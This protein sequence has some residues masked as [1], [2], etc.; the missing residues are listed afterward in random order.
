MQKKLLYMVWHRQQKMH[1][2][3]DQH[4]VV[5]HRSVFEPM[6]PAHR[7]QTPKKA[8]RQERR[9]PKKK[10]SKRE[11]A[12][13]WMDSGD[14]SGE[15]SGD[16][17]QSA[18]SPEAEAEAAPLPDMPEH[19]DEVKTLAEFVR[20]KP[21]LI[22]SAVQI[23]TQQHVELCATA[24]RLRYF[25]ADLFAEVY[26]VLTKRFLTNEIDARAATEIAGHLT[27]LNAYDEKVFSAAIASLEPRFHTLSKEQRLR[28]LSILEQ[29]QHRSSPA[30]VDALRAAP[31][32]EDI[33]ITTS[34]SGKVPC[35]H[36]ARGFCSL[37]RACT[38]AH[39]E[40]LTPP[41]MLSPTVLTQ[42][43]FT[44][45]KRSGKPACRHFA[46]GF[47]AMGKACGFLHIDPLAAV[48]QDPA[49]MNLLGQQGAL[50]QGVPLPQ[51]VPPR[52]PPPAVKTKVCIHFAAGNC[53]WGA[54]CHFLHMVPRP[55]AM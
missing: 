29:V 5:F 34:S 30:F 31:V 26:K 35:R 53:T 22:K 44:M 15:G 25:D 11:K 18:A 9:N 13:A 28:W 37:G 16:E 24:S 4:V 51:V 48:A 39:E 52:G 17:K 8:V 10:R 43:Q 47:C 49:T 14:E 3:K 41:P 7:W 6:Q 42:T 20:L 21:T 50:V 46:R 2:S 38:F 40:G 12:F 23:S 19:L 45:E 36:F 33:P 27:D 32:L 54:N 1:R 55:A